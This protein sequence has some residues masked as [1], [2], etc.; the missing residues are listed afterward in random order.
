MHNTELS[1]LINRRSS[2]PQDSPHGV[3]QLGK[4][5]LVDSAGIA[6]PGIAFRN[7]NNSAS[8]TPRVVA[9]PK[10]LQELIDVVKNRDYP[11]PIR[12]GG[13][14]HSLNPCF[15][16]DGTQILL[17]HFD[18]V[19]VDVAALTVTVGASVEMI[20]I[21]NAL[22]PH[23]M[24]I[25]VAPE[26]GNATAGSVACC[27][28]KDASLGR[29]GPGQV[30]STVIGVKLVNADGDLETITEEGDPEKMR[31]VRSSYGLLG[32]VFEVTF[33]IQRQ[34]VLSYRHKVFDLTSP[35]TREKLFGDADGI[36]GF[37]LPYSNRIV[38]EQR[39]VLGESARISSFSRLKRLT[40]DKIWA[41]KASFFTTLVPYNWF[42]RIFDEALVL[43]FRILTLLG[44][45]RARRA[46]S[47]INYKFN[48][49]NYFDFTFWAIPVSRWEEFIPRY[50]TFCRDYFRE[51][52]FRASLVSSVYFI[53]KDQHALLSFSSSEDIFTMDLADSR[54]NDPRW[55]EFNR[56]YD[57]FVVQFGARPLLNQT[58]QLS[59]DVVYQTLGDDWKQLL[60]HREQSDPS[61]RFLSEYF[62]DL[63]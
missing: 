28:T 48:R 44:G 10:N 34:S 9:V 19:S 15:A 3:V 46:D 45:F 61:G 62:A 14:F 11:S 32:V 35:P 23:G 56:R 22:R 33:R 50:L 8:S 57:N 25:E 13:S 63:M 59:R 41:D 18:Q 30:S 12:V 36:L 29:F 37:C 6:N 26:I 40:R 52:G 27:G 43:A 4:V 49:T 60:S 2:K 20:Q 47:N 21:R 16:T 1:G 58:K 39:R 51:T 38:V 53:N 17:S 31:A 5:M 42:F 7:W 55:I 54:P 24:Q